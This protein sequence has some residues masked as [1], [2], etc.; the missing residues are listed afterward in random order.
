MPR[1]AEPTI[2]FECNYHMT[3][4]LPGNG[5]LGS[6]NI[7]IGHVADIHIADSSL[8]K[9][10]LLDVLKLQPITRLGYYDYSSVESKFQM[11]IPWGNERVC[12]SMEGI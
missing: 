3:L 4:C 6:A 2:H 7:V 5:N 12:G 10:G 1:V 9:D 8:I 11:V